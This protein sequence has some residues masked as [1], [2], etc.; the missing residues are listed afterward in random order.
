MRLHEPASQWEDTHTHTNTHA[1]AAGLWSW[2][3]WL[4]RGLPRGRQGRTG[5][6]CPNAFFSSPRGMAA[7]GRWIKPLGLVGSAPLGLEPSYSARHRLST[8]CFVRCF[9]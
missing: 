5:K 4:R 7:F 2:P 3:V 1:N 8:K 9:T 6:G